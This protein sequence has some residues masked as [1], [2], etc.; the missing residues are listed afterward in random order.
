MSRAHCARSAQVV[1]AAARTA[2][3]SYAH[4]RLV[5][6]CCACPYRDPRP[7]LPSRCAYVA[8]SNDVA[9]QIFPTTGGPC[10]DI[11]TT[12][13]RPQGHTRS[14]PQNGVA[15]LF[16]LPSLKPGRDTKTRSRPSWRLTYVA[17][18]FSCRDLVPAHSGISRWRRQNPG[19]DLPHCHPCRDLKMMSRPQIQ[20]AKSQ[21]QILRSQ[22]QKAIPRRDLKSM[23]RHRFCLIRTNEVATSKRG[24]HTKSIVSSCDAKIPSRQA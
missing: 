2:S 14:R 13:R 3:W 15:T 5:A 9:T 24:R 19:R 12:S 22:L 23:S 11:K 18:S 16:L 17:T 8:T 20:L 6:L 4:A 21:P 1:G 7:K 10:H